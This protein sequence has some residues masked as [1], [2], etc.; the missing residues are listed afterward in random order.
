MNKTVHFLRQIHPNFVI[1]GVIS[2]QAFSVDK[3]AFTHQ[4]KTMVNYLPM[5]GQNSPFKVHLNIIQKI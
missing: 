3:Q 5:T 2:G 1:N 4:Q